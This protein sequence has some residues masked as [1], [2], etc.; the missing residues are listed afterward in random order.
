MNKIEKNIT[1]ES[2]CTTFRCVCSC[3][4]DPMTSL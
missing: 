3:K 2:S 4:G 1:V